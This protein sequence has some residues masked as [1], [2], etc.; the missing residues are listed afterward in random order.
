MEKELFDLI[1]DSANATYD[2]YLYNVW[3]TLAI[4]VASIGWLLTSNSARQF[5]GTQ[6]KARNLSITF[7]ILIAVI[8]L[9]VLYA[10]Q[11][12]SLRIH[13]LLMKD[14]YVNKSEVA[15]EYFNQYLIPWYFPLFSFVLTGTMFLLLIVFITKTPRFVEKKESNHRIA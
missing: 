15:F 13:D 6:R 9:V 2:S 7:L 14:A 4:A 5:L 11:I 1:Y 8:H 10:T 3:T 12:K